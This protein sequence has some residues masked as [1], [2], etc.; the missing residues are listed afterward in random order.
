MTIMLS[1]CTARSEGS[2][3]RMQ[4]ESSAPRR[5]DKGDSREEN[6][7]VCAATLNNDDE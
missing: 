7:R 4:R 6:E 1:V 2:R 5:T 3:R